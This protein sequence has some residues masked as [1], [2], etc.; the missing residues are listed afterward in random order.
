MVESVVPQI[1]PIAV[2]SPIWLLRFL[3]TFTFILHI[4]AMNFVLGGGI[5][6]AVNEMRGRTTGL[7]HHFDL[8]RRLSKGLPI[9][10]AFTINLGVPPLLFLQV[11][12]GQ[13]FYTSSIIMAWPWLSVIVLVILAYYGYYLYNF[14][15]EKLSG[16]RWWFVGGSAFLLTIVA[17]LYSNNMTLM[18]TPATWKAVYVDSAR[19]LFL[20]LGEGTL[21]PRFLH[22]FVAALAVGGLIVILYGLAKRKTEPEFARWAMRQGSWWFIIPTLIQFFIGILFL[23]TLPRDVMMLLM[24]ESTIGTVFFLIG[25][26]GAIAAVLVFF[27]SLQREHPGPYLY[28]GLVIMLVTVVSMVI[29]RDVVRSGYIADFFTLDQ[30][31][32]DPQTGIIILFFLLFIGGLGIVAWMLRKTL[33][34]AKT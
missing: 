30:L 3:L 21:V 7:Q 14:R 1:D 16:R 20:N 28:V 27:I 19:G 18:V 8:S 12:Y 13:F 11:L 15:F 10:M 4:L 25:I 32:V 34:A 5:I 17:F 26:A 9:A 22:F 33:E 6:A 24:G 29:V 2:P 31:T 23:M